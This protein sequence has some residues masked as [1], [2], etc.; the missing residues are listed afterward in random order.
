MKLDGT[1]ILIPR[2]TIIPSDSNNSI[3]F[4]RKQFPVKPCY[5]MTINRAQGQVQRTDSL[6]RLFY[7]QMYLSITYQSHLHHKVLILT[8]VQDFSKVGIDLTNPCFTHGQ[9]CV[10][11][12]RTSKPNDIKI[13]MEGD[14][15]FTANPVYRECLP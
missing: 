10:A 15:T 8:W 4:K 7:V 1:I 2:I 6:I 13:L 9:L 12:S 5:A 11:L 14:E 3:S